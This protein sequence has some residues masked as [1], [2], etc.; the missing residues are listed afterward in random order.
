MPEYNQPIDSLLIQAEKAISSVAELIARHDTIISDHAIL[1]NLSKQVEELSVAIK[2]IQSVLVD[3]TD[4]PSIMT[5]LLFIEKEITAIRNQCSNCPMAENLEEIESVLRTY[6]KKH[7]DCQA[8]KHLIQDKID[9]LTDDFNARQSVLSDIRNWGWKTI[10]AV[11]L[12][13]F[14][15]LGIWFSLIFKDGLLRWLKALLTGVV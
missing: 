12:T 4:K 8:A 2:H 6:I 3:S 11:L 5:R 9:T 13:S 10:G 7:E 14:S 15:G 1:A